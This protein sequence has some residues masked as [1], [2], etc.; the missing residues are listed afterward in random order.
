MRFQAVQSSSPTGHILLE[1]TGDEVQ[2]MGTTPPFATVSVVARQPGLPPPNASE[3]LI[4]DA[5]KHSPSLG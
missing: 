3:G 1:R 2:E 5:G 4:T